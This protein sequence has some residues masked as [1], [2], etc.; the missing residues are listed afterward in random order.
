MSTINDLEP[1]KNEYIPEEVLDRETESEQLRQAL[2]NRQNVHV[3][4]PRGTGKTL[5]V[6]KQLESLGTNV[7]YIS[8]QR[9]DTQYKVLRKTVNELTS[10][11]V[12]SG[13]HTSELQRLLKNQVEAVET[14]I[15]LDDLDFLLLNDGDDLL[16]FLSRI[17]ADLGLVLITANH[18]ELRDQLEERTFSTLQPQRIGF[19][20]FTGE[21]IYK[22]LADRAKNSMKPRSLRRE[23]LT[24]IASSTQNLAA[25]LT[26]LRISAQQADN[27]VTEAHTK[28]LISEALQQYTATQLRDFTQH[29][30]LLYQAIEKLESDQKSS[31]RTGDVHLKY[32]EL[33]QTYGQKPLTE[34]RT[35]DYLKQLEQ[36]KLITSEYH[37]GGRKGKTR[38]INRVNPYSN[39]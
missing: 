17:E 24:Y 34:R 7:C 2:E 32:R 8:C 15:V 3:H 23:A 14:T 36:L 6:K 10:K 29:H 27:V 31:V 1:L 37:Y 28:R 25:A 9:Q 30:R 18:R 33:C 20:P 13:H 22:V 16:Y 4:G 21:E 38:E 35:S 19:E 39:T 5:I 12:G 11:T 26:W